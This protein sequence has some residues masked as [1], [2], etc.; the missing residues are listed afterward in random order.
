MVGYDDTKNGGSFLFVN[1]WGVDWGDEGYFWITYKDFQQNGIYGFVIDLNEE[2]SASWTKQG[3][4]NEDYY[5]GY[6]YF[7]GEKTDTKFEGTVDSQSN[8]FDGDINL[9]DGDGFCGAGEYKD[10]HPNDWWILFDYHRVRSLSCHH[11]EHR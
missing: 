3:Y 11:I 2:T 10:G 4:S 5:K 8:L 6:I 9:I 7:D 1:S